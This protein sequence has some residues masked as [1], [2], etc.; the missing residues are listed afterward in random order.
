MCGTATAVCALLCLISVQ[1]K[2][3][4]NKPRPGQGLLQRTHLQ[5]RT[6]RAKAGLRLASST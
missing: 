2:T 1:G 5:M 6:L 4:S 3:A